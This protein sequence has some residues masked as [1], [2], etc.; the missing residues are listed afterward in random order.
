MND[1]RTYFSNNLLPWY[2]EHHRD[3]PWRKTKDPYF[4]W[5]S[6][7]ILQ[8]TRVDQGMPYYRHFIEKYP[9]VKS[10][11]NASE[12]EV[13]K[14]WEGLGYYSRARNLHA[15]AKTIVSDFQGV[16]PK[17]MKDI[18]N[19]KGVGPY[20]S[21][22]IGSFAFGHVQAAI[23]G[24]AYRVFS[25]FLQIKA[26]IDTPKGKKQ[27]ELI[28]A[29]L[30]DQTDPASFNQA[31]MELGA[32]ICT[33][34]KPLCQECPLQEKCLSAHS[35]ERLN[36]PV[37]SKKIKKKDRYFDYLV[38]QY[39]G[40][41]LIRERKNKDIWSGLN[42]FYLIENTVPNSQKVLDQTFHKIPY[43]SVKWNVHNQKRILTHQR[44]FIT[45]HLVEL[46]KSLMLE[47]FRWISVED[48]KDFAFPKTLQLF[49]EQ[50]FGG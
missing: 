8:Q 19:L 26:A 46:Q 22:A 47:D 45:F 41:V 17:E 14:S 18:R 28:G 37:K 29:E 39:Q 25:R 5:L 48:I 15:A 9:T 27:F 23:D 1:L 3:L 31:I 7:I 34:K 2:K 44:L 20:T 16:F 6:E 32:T 24:N 30:I 4:I 10:L 42:E 12:Q 49:V 33:P 50:H 38:L 21:A 35:P 43:S 36:L 13:F 11:A 40:K